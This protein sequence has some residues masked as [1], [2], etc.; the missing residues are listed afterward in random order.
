M[1]TPQQ[2]LSFELIAAIP[3]LMNLLDYSINLV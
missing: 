1:P 3:Q 2:A